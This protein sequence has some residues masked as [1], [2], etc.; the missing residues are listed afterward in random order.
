MK[1]WMLLMIGYGLYLVFFKKSPE[2]L[3]DST[4]APKD[5]MLVTYYP[6]GGNGAMHETHRKLTPGAIRLMEKNPKV[7]KPFDTNF[8]DK[9]TEE[10]PFTEV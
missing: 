9:N 4:E 8:I 7:P 5:T 10:I 2:V 3:D 1:L 6:R